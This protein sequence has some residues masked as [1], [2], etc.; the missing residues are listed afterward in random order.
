MIMFIKT[1]LLS[2][3]QRVAR[4]LLAVL[5][6]LNLAFIFIHS[7]MPPEVVKEEAD[8][9]SDIVSDIVGE[10]SA[11]GELAEDN[12]DKIAH[13]T[14]FGFLGFLVS[15]YVISFAVNPLRRI[16][17]LPIFS[18]FIAGIDETIQIFSGR[19]PDWRD[20]LVDVIGFSVISIIIY[21]IF[22]VVRTI[23]KK[24]F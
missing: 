15:V 17:A 2:V 3:K 18:A 8:V 21:I 20:A 23:K 16:F 1:N 10:D 24:D 14:E 7:M 6:I 22:F 4:F 12:M 9:A 5:I 13:F 19:N 11:A